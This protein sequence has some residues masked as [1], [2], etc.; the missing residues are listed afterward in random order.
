MNKVGLLLLVALLAAC[1]SQNG[2]YAQRHDSHPES[3]SRNID[4]ADVTPVY[5]TYNPAN[6][7]PYTVLGKHYTPLS[8]GKGFS[9]SGVASWYGQKFHGH[10]T[11]NGEVYDMF[12]MTAAHKTLPL[13]SFVRVTNVDNGRQAIVRVNDRGPFHHNRVIDLSYAAAMKLGV[14]ATGTANVKLEVMHVDK[15]GQLTVGAK[16]IL[17]PPPSQQG[18]LYIQVAA[19]SDAGR[20]EKMA[21]GLSQLYQVPTQVP[22][23]NGVYRLRLGPLEDESQAVALLSELH[24]NGYAGAYKMYVAP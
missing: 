2:R 14:L 13:P 10:T 9:E 4:F 17:P 5:V 8:S 12:A 24:S 16:P 11:A 20:I 7:R 1:T 6:L 18:K 21:Q 3:I 15:A 23:D 22:H 19:L